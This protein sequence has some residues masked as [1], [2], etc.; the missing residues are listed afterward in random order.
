MRDNKYLEKGYCDALDIFAILVREIERTENDDSSHNETMHKPDLVNSLCLA[1][2]HLTALC[3]AQDLSRI[4]MSLCRDQV[5]N[6]RF[7]F[8]QVRKRLPAEK[9]KVFH[10][11]EDNLSK[12]MNGLVCPTFL[13]TLI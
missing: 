2:Y 9:L 8:S 5:D 3:N 7:S 4:E 11:L 10:Q 6:L 12:D 1:I 13:I